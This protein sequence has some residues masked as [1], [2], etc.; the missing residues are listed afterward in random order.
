MDQGDELDMAIK[1]VLAN[2]VNH[3]LVGYDPNKSSPEP[4]TEAK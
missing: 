4:Q 2:L 1:K 3:V